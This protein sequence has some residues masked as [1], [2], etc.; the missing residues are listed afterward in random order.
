ME[1]NLSICSAPLNSCRT[2]TRN[3]C[4]TGSACRRSQR[5]ANRSKKYF[6]VS[7]AKHATL[8]NVIS[9]CLSGSQCLCGDLFVSYFHHRDTKAALRH[10]EKLQTR[11]VSTLISN[12]KTES[13]PF[14]L[15][16]ND[17]HQSGDSD[18]ASAHAETGKRRSRS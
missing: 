16:L 11:T 5:I 7:R 10:R 14:R 1:M 2:S 3:W 8:A 9:Q 12:L 6:C 18:C 13:F 4:R 15:T 17:S